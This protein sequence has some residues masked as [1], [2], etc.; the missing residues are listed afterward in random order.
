[1][2]GTRFSEPLIE[3]KST[4]DQSQPFFYHGTIPYPRSA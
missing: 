2:N 3:A 4:F 1:M